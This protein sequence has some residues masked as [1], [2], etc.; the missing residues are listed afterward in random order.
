MLYQ[1]KRVGISR[2]DL[3]TVYT[4]VVR[5]VIEYACHVCYTNLPTYISDSI[6]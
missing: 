4:I 6:E 3:V 1:L 5:P 2:L